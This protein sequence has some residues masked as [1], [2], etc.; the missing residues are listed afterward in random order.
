MNLVGLRRELSR[1]LGVVDVAVDNYY[2][3][4]HIHALNRGQD[5]VGMDLHIPTVV[6]TASATINEVAWPAT[7]RRGGLLSVAAEGAFGRRLLSVTNQDE[8]ERLRGLLPASGPPALAVVLPAA[9]R[10]IPITGLAITYTLSG[11]GVNTAMTLDADTPWTGQHLDHAQL[12][13]LYAGLYLLQQDGT[14][15]SLERLQHLRQLYDRERVE[16]FLAIH[17]NRGVAPANLRFLLPQEV[18]TN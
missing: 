18:K 16:S 12:I 15:R 8:A 10:F 2:N 9:I 7:I 14:G 11:V 6:T 13:A 3:V 17:P 5:A 4:N 1:Y